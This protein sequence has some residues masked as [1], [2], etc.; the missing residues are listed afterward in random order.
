MD[1]ALLEIERDAVERPNTGEIPGDVLELQE[2]HDHVYTVPG[3]CL[4]PNKKPGVMPGSFV[5][6]DTPPHWEVTVT[7]LEAPTSPVVS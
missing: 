2:R 3:G 1:L 4:S 7:L 6:F 5:L